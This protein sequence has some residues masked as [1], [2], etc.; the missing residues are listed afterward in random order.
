A[1]AEEQEDPRAELVQQL[2]EHEKFKNA[3]QMLHQKQTVQSAMWSAPALKS[4]L[5]PDEDQTL[6]VTL[7]DLV[8]AFQK[9]L[10]RAKEKPIMAIEGESV[11]V[12]DM[13]RKLCDRLSASD[14]PPALQDLFSAL[15]SRE[16]L[17][18]AF[19]ALLELVRLQA[20]V[21]RQKERFGEIVLY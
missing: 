4:F 20:I 9:V 12:A 1:P 18:A 2:L 21:A 14:E 3:A 8:R 13:M 16:A 11:S 10:E 5:Q 7:V 15:R 17:L 19:L 6:A